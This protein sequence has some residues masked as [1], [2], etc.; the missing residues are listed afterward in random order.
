AIAAV[1]GVIT[2]FFAPYIANIFA[3]SSESAFM[4]PS[5]AAFLQVMC[6]FFVVVPL[7]ITASSVFQAMG[8]GMTS[9]ALTVIREVLFISVFAYIFAF[10]LGLGS[11]GVWWGIVVGGACGCAIAFLWAKRY[12]KG[13][14]RNYIKEETQTIGVVPGK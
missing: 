12:I 8:K 2:Y 7:G 5:I 13:L 10:T 11:H 4:A 3:Y 6:L 1:T 9:L 14:R